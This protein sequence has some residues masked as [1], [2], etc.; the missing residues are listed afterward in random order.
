MTAHEYPAP[1]SPGAGT[2][3][4]RAERIT[5]PAAGRVFAGVCAG[6]ADH[7]GLTVKAV[8]WT[9]FLAAFL[10]GAGILA[11]GLLWAFTPVEDDLDP[12]AESDRERVRK[13]GALRLVVLG[14]LVIILAGVLVFAPGAGA[15]LSSSQLTLIG[16]GMAVAA[17]L[18]LAWT[19][20]DHVDLLRSRGAAPSSARGGRWQA[21]TLWLV[22]LLGASLVVGGVLVLTVGSQ[23]LTFTWNLVMATLAVLVG[24][25][26]VVMPWGVRVWRR[27]VSE[28]ETR[29]RETERADIAAH[30]HDSVLQTLALIQRTDDVT[31]VKVLARAQERELRRWLYGGADKAPES[32]A[33]AAT[34]MAHQVEDDHGVPIDLVVTGD[35]PL[36][37]G[38]IALVRALREALLNAVR[39]GAPPVSAYVEVG[40][41]RVEAFVRDH[42]PGFDI[43]DVPEDRFGVKESIIG[44]MQRAGGSARIRRLDDGIEV[45]L[46]LDVE[47]AAEPA[48]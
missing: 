41:R 4:W 36:D 28:Q 44:R 26:I 30:L 27:F 16:G 17:G 22:P 32:L 2:P 5:R 38:T 9:F 6:T 19:Y 45:E 11:Y 25:G 48:P 18:Y 24:I 21:A 40:S 46:T 34:A 47:A 39:H 7:L 12:R 37:E 33:A 15:G 10:G 31:R 23:G 43:D 14:A 8:R 29:I 20:L 13:S 35:R 3:P 1:G 42:G